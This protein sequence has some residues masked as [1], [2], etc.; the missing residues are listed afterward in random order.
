MT[1]EEDR[2]ED[3]Q[4]DFLTVEQRPDT[5]PRQDHPLLKGALPSRPLRQ[6]KPL[7][8]F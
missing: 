8:M 1:K 5:S 6:K 3:T 4:K 7:N 2:D